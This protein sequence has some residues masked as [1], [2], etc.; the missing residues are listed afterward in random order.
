MLSH[1]EARLVASEVLYDFHSQC[2]LD[3]EK[4]KLRTAARLIKEDTKAMKTCQSSYPSVDQ[5]QS[6][7]SINFL[8]NTSRVLLLAGI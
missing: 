2:N 7:Q 1:L 5:L 8:P 4:E 6:D 3:P